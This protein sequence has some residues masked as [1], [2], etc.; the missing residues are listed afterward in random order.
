[1]YQL[2][3][4]GGVSVV[5]CFLFYFTIW[6]KPSQN[7]RI[8]EEELNYLEQELGNKGLSREVSLT[9]ISRQHNIRHIG[10]NQSFLVNRMTLRLDSS[11][12]I[13][14][15]LLSI[16]ITGMLKPISS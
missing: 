15:N 12:L 3:A 5:W 9:N 14:Q 13:R 16:C 1:M 10:C 11:Y 8:S 2:F 4:S 7:P 6:D